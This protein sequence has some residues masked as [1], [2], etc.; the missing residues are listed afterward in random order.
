VTFVGTSV[1]GYLFGDVSAVPIPIAAL[2]LNLVL[3]PVTLVLLSIATGAEDSRGEG[4]SLRAH[5]VTAVCEP[6]V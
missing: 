1:L 4:R 2:A 5:I 3:V 6:V